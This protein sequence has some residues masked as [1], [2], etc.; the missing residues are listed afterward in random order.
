MSEDT[1][2]FID[3]MLDD[4]TEAPTPAPETEQAEEPEQEAASTGEQEQPEAEAEAPEAEASADNAGPP[5]DAEKEPQTVPV[6]ALRDERAKR[7]ALEQELARFRALQEQMTQQQAPQQKPDFF[8]NPEAV[9]EERIVRATAGLSYQMAVQQ[10]GEDTVR[11]A[12]AFFNDPRHA[13]K[14]RELLREASPFH[15]AVS[16]YKQ[17]QALSEIGDDPAAYRARL[18]AELREKIA[19]EMAHAQPS[20]PKAPPKSLSAA[21][22]AG[23]PAM[24]PGNVLDEVFGSP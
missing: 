8:E 22:S 6:S 9:L 19:A 18:E 14:S 10:Y 4:D 5:P 20:R 7:Q 11:E 17:Q 23:T 21:P 16:Y 2:G 13:P 3:A 1:R 12:V 15:A 24:S